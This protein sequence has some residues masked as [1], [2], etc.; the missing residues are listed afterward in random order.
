MDTKER[1]ASVWIGVVLALYPV[2]LWF[3]RFKAERRAWWASYL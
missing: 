2:C 3:A 1:L